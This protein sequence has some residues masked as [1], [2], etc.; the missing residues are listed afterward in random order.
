[1]NKP[2][3]LRVTFDQ[4]PAAKEYFRD[5]KP[6]DQCRLEP[7]SE[8][9]VKAID[10]QGVDLIVEAFIPEGYERADD[11]DENSKQNLPAGGPMNTEP[12]MT[13]AAM[14]VRKRAN[15]T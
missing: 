6:G 1:M 11:G 12:N 15:R 14:M 7:D 10:D 13:P 9:T 4:N 5:K 2:D 3:E 8:F